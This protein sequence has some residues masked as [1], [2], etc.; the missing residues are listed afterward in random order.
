MLPQIREHARVA[1]RSVRPESKEDLI[2]EVVANACC[3][4]QRLV[5]RG[6]ED[7]AYPTPL[8][9]FAIRHVRAGRRVGSRVNIRDVASPYARANRGIVLE[10]LDQ[11]DEQ[12]DEWRESLIEDRRAGPAE[13]AAARIDLANWFKALNRK[14]RKIAQTLARGETTGM[15]AHMYGLSSARVSQLRQEL[16]R[17]WETFQGEPAVA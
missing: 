11:F 15:V 2:A 7:L 17:S 10:R 5:E 14:K 13:T 6:K 16:K 12:E 3:A 8:A 1:F 4:Y 9:M